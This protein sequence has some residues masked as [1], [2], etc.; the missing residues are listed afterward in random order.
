MMFIFEISRPF[1][2][3]ATFHHTNCMIRLVWLWFAPALVFRRMDEFADPVR[4][5]W[6]QK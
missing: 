5:D 1:Q 6:G 4:Y 2:W 3:K